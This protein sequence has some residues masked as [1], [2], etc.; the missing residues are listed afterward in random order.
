MVAWV[1]PILS[2]GKN[3]MTQKELSLEA[4]KLANE[5]RKFEIGL[6][7]TRYNHMWVINSVA[8]A[9]YFVL[10][11]ECWLASKRLMVGLAIVRLIKTYGPL[12]RS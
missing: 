7:W 4:L 2:F 1:V 6:F 10:Q 12:V 8:L 3:I 9:G 5:T 11:K